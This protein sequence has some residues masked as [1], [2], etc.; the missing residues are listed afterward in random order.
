MNRQ[1]WVRFAYSR[2]GGPIAII[3]LFIICSTPFLVLGSLFN[4]SYAP[5]TALPLYPNIQALMLPT[6]TTVG[7]A[8]APSPTPNP[9]VLPESVPDYAFTTTDPH[10]AVVRFYKATLEKL[11]GPQ[12]VR[13]ESPD[14]NLTMLYGSRVSRYNIWVVEQTRVTVSTGPDGVTHVD[15]KLAVRPR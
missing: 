12:S 14:S 9:I 13:V 4:T 10:E 1:S 5:I 2:P 7:L 3:L 6:A 8:S 11:Y 15:L